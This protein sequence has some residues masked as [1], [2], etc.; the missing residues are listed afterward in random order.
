MVYLLMYYSYLFTYPLQGSRAGNFLIV[1]FATNG[2]AICYNYEEGANP[3]RFSLL[4]F[5][6]S[7]RLQT[8]VRSSL[9]I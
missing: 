6:A 3:L 1:A 5:S 9:S 7:A 2:V 8:R 4:D